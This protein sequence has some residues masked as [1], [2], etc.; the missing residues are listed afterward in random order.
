MHEGRYDFFTDEDKTLFTDLI[1]DGAA[2]IFLYAR[3]ILA[4]GEL[5]LYDPTDPTVRAIARSSIILVP[6]CF[7][8]DYFGIHP[9][10]EG[11]II[12]LYKDNHTLHARIEETEYS[13]DG[14]PQAFPCAPCAKGSHT[15]LPAQAV[16]EHFSIPTGCFYDNMLL[17]MGSESVLQTMRENPCLAYAG[18]YAVF[19]DFSTDGLTS[20]D[21]T[22]VKDKWRLS[23]VG[24]KAINDAGDPEM[25][26]KLRQISEN[27]R[28]A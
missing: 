14:Q 7:F 17:V 15:Y 26:L 21:Y 12:V 25:A 24:S 28:R 19:G 9:S 11:E 18:G 3:T 2:A 6:E 27:C 8:E 13:F 5:R 10:R 16:C 1:T 23:L 20:E 4:D 22:A